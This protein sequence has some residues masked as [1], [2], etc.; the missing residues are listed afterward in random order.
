MRFLVAD[1]RT[2]IY[3]FVIN[4]RTYKRVTQQAMNSASKADGKPCAQR[5]KIKNDHESV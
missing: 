3:G 4:N 5:Y 2:T 1:K